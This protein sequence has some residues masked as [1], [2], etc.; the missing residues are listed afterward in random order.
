MVRSSNEN[1]ATTGFGDLAFGF[2][3]DIA[4][5]DD[6]GNIGEAAF[7]E[8][9]GV[10]E[11]EKVDDGG[12][13]LRSAFSEVLVLGFLGKQAPKL[14]RLSVCNSIQIGSMTDL[15]Q[16]DDGLP[17]VVALEVEVAHTDFTKVTGMVLVEVGTVVVLTTSHTTTTRVLAVLSY[18]AMAGRDMAAADFSVYR[19]RRIGIE[20]HCFLVLDKW[21]GIVSVCGWF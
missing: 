19:I 1:D 16:V 20:T 9:F 17:F 2:L 12:G 15:V 7:A 4:S 14:G 3:A 21:V 18:T 11:S 5:L 13:V 8:D 10:S 6:N